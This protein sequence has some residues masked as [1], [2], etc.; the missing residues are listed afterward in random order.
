MNSSP[1]HI[2]HLIT[3]I[4]RRQL[5]TWVK[6]AWVTGLA[7]VV[8][9][10]L[11]VVFSEAL[12]WFSPGVRQ[13]LLYGITIYIGIYLVTILAVTIILLTGKNYPGDETIARMIW[14][15]DREIR[16]RILNALQLLRQKDTS[17][18]IQLRLA[19]VDEIDRQAENIAA[20]P[21]I[22][23]ELFWKA[24]LFGLIIAS[25]TALSLLVFGGA[26]LKASHRL[27]HPKEEFIRPG[28]VLLDL[29]MPDT[30]SV[31]QGESLL[32]KVRAHLNIP[33][34]VI[35]QL[36]EGAGVERIVESTVDSSDTMLF[37]GWLPKVER[38]FLVFARSLKAISD[39]SFVEVIPRPRI[40]RMDIILSP[41]AYTSTQPI[42][43]PEGV[44]DINA[45]LGS[46]VAVK[47]ESNRRLG[48]ASLVLHRS[49]STLDSMNLAVEDRFASGGFRVETEGSWWIQ[50]IAVDNVENDEPLRWKITLLEDFP[51]LVEVK[52][53]E[54][55]AEIPQSYMVPL[56]V[57]ADDDY[58]IS[59]AALRFRIYNELTT[60]DSVGEDAFMK[61]PLEGEQITPGRLVVQ[62]PWHLE[63]LPLLPTDEIRYF[64][65]AW[66]NDGWH[67]PKRSRSEIR[68]LVFPSMQDLFAEA[69]EHETSV[70]DELLK[71]KEK[72]ESIKEKLDDAL[73]RMRSNPEDLTWEETVALEKALETQQTLMQQLEQATQTLA[74]LQKQ[75]TEHDMA[76][77]EMLEKY[78]KLQE[79]L[80][81]VA[82]PELREAMEKLKEALE[83]QDGQKIREA[84]E[85]LLQ[86]QEAFIESIDRS[87]SILEQL[88]NERKLEELAK[89]AEELARREQDIANRCESAKPEQAPALSFEQKRLKDDFLALMKEVDAMKQT[90]QETD[91]DFSDSLNA[92]QEQLENPSLSEELQQTSDQLKNQQMKQGSNS[93]QKNQKRLQQM[94]QQLSKLNSDFKEKNKNDL[95]EKMDRLYEELLIISRQ[96][97]ELRQSS[98]TLGISSPRYRALAARQSALIQSLK[99]AQEHVGELSKETFFIGAQISGELSLAES[100]MKGAIERYTSRQAQEVSGEQLGA[101]AS[102]HR[103]LYKLAKARDNMQQSSSGTGYEEM[104]EQLSKMAS[105]QQAINQG[106]QGMPMPMP[107][108]MPGRDQ[109]GQL[110]AQQQALAQ[111]M[112]QLEQKAQSMEEL[113]GSLDGLGKSMEEVAKDLDEHNITER[114]RKLQERILQRLLDSQ[115]SLQQRELSR[116]RISRTGGEFERISPSQLKPESIDIL[117]ERM[118][119]AL[120][121][122]YLQSW[123]PVIRDY[124]RALERESGTK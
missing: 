13:P 83:E 113:L 77:A 87:L 98:E 26:L 21:F 75:F 4:R 86:N 117:R 104:M 42:H 92:L 96:Q 60:P 56:V 25:V 51:P 118:L 110:A 18:S 72:A 38:K 82:T 55:G 43:L 94:A 78:A 81:E 64:V 80:E 73:Q 119:K 84:L 48:S 23:H 101:M 124:Y 99:K 5:F 27:L 53:P 9:M 93:A 106:S 12:S 2:N 37:L 122:D 1:K 68:R 63:G 109:L 89:R 65:E 95:T 10:I 19:A 91:P 74:E 57:I 39:T 111:A 50:L 105:Q 70:S 7:A 41:P 121:G 90:L 102:I 52:Q 30:V 15:R 54:D 79:L 61:I 17:S 112:K 107:G 36:N 114:T 29:E 6:A 58:G 59:A 49:G 69:S 40:A 8:G 24:R 16:D 33:K 120:E 116:E 97:E 34:S 123:R 31:I 45:L 100:Q 20:E 88:K 14:S 71:S 62:T 46:R 3:D 22:K 76:T 35:F 115:R 67:G 85:N 44:G 11:L 66:D 28:T 47:V 32:L 108:G 103:S